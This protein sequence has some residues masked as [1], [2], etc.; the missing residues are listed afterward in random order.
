[1]KRNINSTRMTNIKHTLQKLAAAAVLPGALYAPTAVGCLSNTETEE[2]ISIASEKTGEDQAGFSVGPK[3]YVI[4]CIN[5]NNFT[6]ICRQPQS[7]GNHWYYC[8]G[9]SIM[10]P[11]PLP[12]DEPL[13]IEA[14]IRIRPITWGIYGEPHYGMITGPTC[15]SKIRYFPL[16]EMLLEFG[17]LSNPSSV[18]LVDPPPN[19][20]AVV[21][22]LDQL[23]IKV[24]FNAAAPTMQ[25]IQ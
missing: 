4:D 22:D 1:M 13:F 5:E 10:P 23:L 14:D 15:D 18:T 9:L 25:C 7:N 19:Q 2:P 11:P 20:N 3:Y 21:C 17:R 12:D 24:P 6:Y 16:P 8:P